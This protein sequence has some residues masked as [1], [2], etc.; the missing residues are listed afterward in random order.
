MFAHRLAK[1]LPH[2]RPFHGNSG[3][4]GLG[5]AWDYF[6]MP[7]NLKGVTFYFYSCT[8]SL[9]LFIKE[10]K[11]CLLLNFNQLSCQVKQNLLAGPI[12]HGPRRKGSPSDCRSEA[13]VTWVLIT[14]HEREGA[15]DF[16]G[17]C[18]KGTTLG[19]FLSLG[20]KK[21]LGKIPA[22]FECDF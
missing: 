7:K 4:I 16:G 8:G 18:P 13:Y 11:T 21:N 5:K 17:S 19:E 22:N 14:P 2:H 9:P 6:W 10:T 15:M 3:C 20:E 1:S 12:G